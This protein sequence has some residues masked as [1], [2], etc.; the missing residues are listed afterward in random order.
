MPFEIASIGVPFRMQPGLARLAPGA[1]PGLTP[2][3]PGSRHLREKTAVLAAFPELALAAVPAFDAGD[4]LAAIA[5]ASAGAFML[6][7]PG[8]AGAPRIG[9]SIARGRPEG[10]GEPAIGRALEHLPPAQRVAAL[11][12][13]AFDEDLA[14]VDGSSGRVPWLAVA[15][16]SRWAPERKV[17]L[18]L[19]DIHAPVADADSVRAASERL[20]A[21]VSTGRAEDRFERF[22]WT[23]SPDPRLHQHPVHGL[24]GWDAVDDADDADSVAARASLRHERQTFLPVPGRRQAVF[25]IRVESEPLERAVRSAGDAIRLH[26]AIASM[27]PAVLDYKGLAPARDRLLAWLAR[28]AAA[29]S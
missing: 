10:D 20:V 9:W 23:V 21:L 25:T 4:A 27:S 18:S 17:G 14:I 16:P 22:V 1:A 2:A 11:A 5:A 7:G 3:T 19:L 12:C 26:D 29:A 15:L 6:G 24:A 13:L 28:R 8:E